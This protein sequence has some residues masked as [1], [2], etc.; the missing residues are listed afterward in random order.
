MRAT[1]IPAH[2]GMRSGRGWL[3]VAGMARSY[4]PA[5]SAPPL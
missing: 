3:P 4:H 2:A 5:E 1:T